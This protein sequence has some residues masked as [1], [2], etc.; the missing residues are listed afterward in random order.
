M[1]KSL[2][3]INCS[4]ENF[5]DCKH[6]E[7][8]CP[9]LTCSVFSTPLSLLNEQSCML[10]EINPEMIAPAGISLCEKGFFKCSN[11]NLQLEKSYNKDLLGL[12]AM[13]L[14][15]YGYSP[16]FLLLY[17]ETWLLNNCISEFLQS[18]SGLH[19]IGDFYVFCVESDS[20][21]TRT[22]KNN[23]HPGPP[24][25]DRPL[26][27]LQSFSERC[28]YRTNDIALYPHYMSSWFSLTNAT[29]DNSCLYF[30]EKCNDSGYY[31]QGECISDSIKISSVVSQ[32]LSAGGLIAFSHRS[33][34]WGSTVQTT[35][36]EKVIVTSTPETNKNP[37]LPRIALT[38]AYS[39]E[40]FECPYFD[41]ELYLPCPP[42]GL[43][44]GLVCGQQ[45]QYAHLNKLEKY[46]LAL[47]NRIFHSQ[48][49]YF[50]SVYYDKICS[51][52]QL[53]MF[54]HKLGR[55]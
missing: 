21:L 16:L 42:I 54:M 5:L 31:L 26:S 6:W 17:D 30:V 8:I 46:E 47:L 44:L 4:I 45:I 34:H 10:K 36:D 11:E 9:F 40:S 7:K 24:H 18:V 50:N 19:P 53:Q 12:G 39:I 48:K 23:Y 33:L 15:E 22:F 52:S 35:L 29:T 41:H 13:T 49:K 20:Q 43:R 2:Q 27:G 32:P 1:D 3:F 51:S 28:H 25:R 37:S 55:K 14:M 38:T